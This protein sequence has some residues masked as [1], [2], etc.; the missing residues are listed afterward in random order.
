MVRRI[1]Q[2]LA[3]SRRDQIFFVKAL[4]LLMMLPIA[5]RLLGVKRMYRFSQIDRTSRQ[6]PNSAGSISRVIWL[7]RLALRHSPIMG[8]CLSQSLC[9]LRLLRHKGIHAE[10]IVGVTLDGGKFAAHAWV[11]HDGTV[12]NDAADVRHRY[13]VLEGLQESLPF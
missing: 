6:E 10:L 11:E 2:F 9:L 13:Q 5:I 7:Y 8:A 1:R 4:L 3:L 12:L